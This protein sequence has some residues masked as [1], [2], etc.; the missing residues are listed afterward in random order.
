MGHGCFTQYATGSTSHMSRSLGLGNSGSDTDAIVSCNS[1]QPHV[2]IVA[3]ARRSTEI[4]V[5]R[6]WDLTGLARR[7]LHSCC[8][9]HDTARE[10]NKERPRMI[11]E[12]C[13]F[14]AVNVVCP[15]CMMSEK[16]KGA[17]GGVRPKCSDPKVKATQ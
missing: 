2:V 14:P 6:R 11:G 10:S 17:E 13:R 12:R 16:K 4:K 7:H 3:A 9:G 1:S 8:H 15:D 5:F